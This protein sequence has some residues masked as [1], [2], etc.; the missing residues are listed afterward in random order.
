MKTIGDLLKV[1]G[2]RVWS[3]GPTE[4]VF[5][6]LELMAEKDIGALAVVAEGRLV[7]IFSERD[8][9]RKIILQ[10]RA[11][12]TTQVAEVMTSK[13]AVLDPDRTIEEAMALMTDKRLRHFPVMVDGKLAGMV[14]IGDLVKAIISER[15]FVIAQLENYIYGHPSGV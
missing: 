13:V 4:S 9:A 1:K 15:E 12:S 14:S 7:G 3:I 11:S 6:A 2:H 8:Y 10:G 5:A